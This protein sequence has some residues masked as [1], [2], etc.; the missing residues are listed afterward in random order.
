MMTRRALKKLDWPPRTY[1]WRGPLEGLAPGRRQVESLELHN[2]SGDLSVLAAFGDLRE[3]VVGDGEGLDLSPL[4]T[5]ALERLYLRVV[6]S[7]LSPV[8]RL[9]G[10][11]SFGFSSPGEVVVPER[12]ALPASLRRLSFFSEDES[13]R[14]V[15]QV[16]RAIDW[17]RLSDLRSLDVIGDVDEPIRLDWGLLRSLPRLE[18]LEARRGAWHDDSAPSPLEPP[19]DG[20]PR[21]LTWLRIDAWDPDA[22]GPALAAYLGR[23]ADDPPV[24]YQRYPPQGRRPPWSLLEDDDGWQVY[25]SLHERADSDEVETEYDAAELAEQRLRDADPDLAA[26]LVFDPENAGTGIY[27]ASRDDLRRALTI[28]GLPDA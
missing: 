27:A 22:I 26:R 14:A 12:W 20:L 7:D 13:P 28:L 23:P 21:G 19:F 4:T 17:S 11:E 6:G 9:S 18:R 5:L 8:E 16:L 25:G 15:E 10:L 3:L 2:P 24:V 1:R